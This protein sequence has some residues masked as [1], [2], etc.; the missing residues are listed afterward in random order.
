MGSGTKGAEGLEGGRCRDG[1]REAGAKDS[2]W[3]GYVGETMLGRG[4]LG[5]SAGTRRLQELK[6][7]KRAWVE[8]GLCEKG[9]RVGCVDE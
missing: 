5:L 4:Q 1:W 7:R 3:R 6:S 2:G 9:S 8:M